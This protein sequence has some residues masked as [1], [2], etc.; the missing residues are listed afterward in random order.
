VDDAL[1]VHH[2]GHSGERSR[3]DSRIRDWPDVEWRLVR[4]D[5]EPHSPRY[6]SAYGRDVDQPESLLHFNSDTRHLS[7][8]GGNRKQAAA[9]AALADVVKVLRDKDPEKLSLHQIEMEMYASDHSRNAIRDALQLGVRLRTINVEPG[10][11]NAKLHSLL[12]ISAGQNQ[13]ASSPDGPQSQDQTSLNLG[14]EVITAGQ[15]A[16]SD[17][18]ATPRRSSPANSFD[19]AA[20]F[21]RRR[22][23]HDGPDDPASGEHATCIQCGFGLDTQGHQ[24]Q[25]EGK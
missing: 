13:F 24:I 7:I 22:G 16:N 17:D 8:A 5:E 25:C 12:S 14:G 4:E 3:G 21:I 20:A 19:L 18:L 1:V 2:M 9:Q 11:R 10:P 23:E 6:V 15:T